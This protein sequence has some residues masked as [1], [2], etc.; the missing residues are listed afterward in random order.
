VD[1]DDLAGLRR[2]YQSAGLDEADAAADPYAQFADWFRAWRALAVGEP[3]AMVVATAAPDGR[4]SARTVLLKGLNHAGFVF[5]TNYESRKGRELDANPQATLLFSWHPVGRQVVVEGPVERLTAEESDAYWTT[6]PRGSQVGA[7]ASP[8]SEEVPNRKA[9]DE[10][11]ADLEARYAG[12]A[13]PRPSHWGG[14]RVVPDRF[15]F[16]QGRANRVHDRLAY[17]RDATSPAG[18]RLLRLAP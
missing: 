18:W 1:L 16:W 14:Y 17:E 7:A 3:N 6:R 5:Y 15:E 12:V 9:L 13:I 11:F 10:R 4:P 2:E 8:Q